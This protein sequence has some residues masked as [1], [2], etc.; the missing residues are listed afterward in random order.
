M[1]LS[2]L[3]LP[4]APGPDTAPLASCNGWN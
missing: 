2:N 1:P 4:N 3:S